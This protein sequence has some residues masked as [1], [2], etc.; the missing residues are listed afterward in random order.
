MTIE[1]QVCTP[2]QGE[3]LKELGIEQKSLFYWTH[4][5]KWG[6]LYY[7]SIDFSGNPTSVFNV[8]ELGKI[9]PGIINKCKLTQWPISGA[10]DETISYGMQYRFRGNDPVNYGTFPSNTIFGDTEAIVRA[11][12]LIALLEE[13]V[14]TAEEVNKR[15]CA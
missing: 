8:A 10:T 15:L 3:K 14:L 9:L 1:D 2:S 11:N 12:L 7:T 6:I 5:K 13:K 4:S